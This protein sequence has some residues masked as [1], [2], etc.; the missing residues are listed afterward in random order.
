METEIDLWR[1]SST[2]PR[3][4]VDRDQVDIPCIVDIVSE[5]YRQC[6]AIPHSCNDKLYCNSKQ[7]CFSIK[8]KPPA[9]ERTY[10]YARIY[11]VYSCDLDLEP[12]TLPYKNDLDILKAQLGTK[13]EVS[14]SRL[15]KVRTRK[16]QTYRQTRP[17]ALP[18]T[19]AGSSNTSFSAHSDISTTELSVTAGTC[20]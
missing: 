16:R 3:A 8:G 4:S 20:K 1:G 6:L 14:R 5:I 17:N 2:K 10:G 19:F 18:T 7:D 15:S 11:P 12:M 13:N 9:N